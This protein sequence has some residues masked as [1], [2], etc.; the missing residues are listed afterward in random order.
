MKSYQVNQKGKQSIKH[1]KSM[2]VRRSINQQASIAVMLKSFNEPDWFFVDKE[3]D[4][5][6]IKSINKA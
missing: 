6:G 3:H 5:I 1:A 4:S 2:S